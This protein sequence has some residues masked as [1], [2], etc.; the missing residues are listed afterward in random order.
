MKKIKQSISVHVLAFTIVRIALNS[1][2]RMVYPFLTVFSR[3]L[4]VGLPAISTAFS[5]RSLVGVVG[6]FLASIADKYGRKRGMQLGLL[7]FTCGVA[8]VVIQPTFPVFVASMMLSVLGK[9]VFDASVQAYL[10]DRVEYKKRGL[11]LAVSELGWSLSFIVGIPL[12]GFVITRQGWIAPFPCL[13]LLGLLAVI[14][15][16]WLIPAERRKLDK[17]E[18][19]LKK[20]RAV[21][22]YKPAL[23]GLAMGVWISAA[24]ELVNL[25]FGVWLEDSFGVKI[26]ALGAASAVIGISELSGEALVAGL[27]DRLGKS[28]SVFLGLAL[29]SLAAIMLPFLGGT[30]SGAFIG[31]FMFYITFEFALVSSIPMMTEVMPMARATLMA[32]NVAGLSLGRSLGALLASPLYLFGQT[33][34]QFPHLISNFVSGITVSAVAAVI[35]NLV[36]I[37]FL[38]YLRK[39]IGEG[40]Q[41]I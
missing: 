17:Q 22:S 26:A 34:S 32:T 27:A 21:I 36:G 25:V 5:L 6:P 40:V 28:R 1:T 39:G 11:V 8:I 16:T 31:L 4:G 15:I 38:R 3:G 19:I 33:F 10:G 12:I 41:G 9:I 23:A 2:H 20:L 29:N 7:I 35:F 37:V 13:A 24:N 30:Q 14:G 18:G